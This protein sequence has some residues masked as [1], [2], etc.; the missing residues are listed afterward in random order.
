MDYLA[1]I[2]QAG[3]GA[4]ADRMGVVTVEASPD[5]L[6]MTMPVEG[7]TQPI[8]LLHGGASAVLAETAGSILSMI[9]APEGKVPVGIELSCTHHKSARDGVV[10]ATATLLSTGR[11][12]STTSI[13]ITNTSGD[14]VCSARLSCYYVT[15]QN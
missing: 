3:L 11:T 1:L 9:N 15:P 5:R 4:L 10:T 2:N 13:V 8:G 14:R 12:L 6:V 7:N